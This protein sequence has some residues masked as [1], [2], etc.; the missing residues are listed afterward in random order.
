LNSGCAVYLLTVLLH[1]LELTK[2][3]VSMQK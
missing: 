3:D 1:C 2:F